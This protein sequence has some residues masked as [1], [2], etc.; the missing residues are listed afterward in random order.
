MHGWCGRI[1][2]VD[3]TRGTIAEEALP[4]E[5][6]RD[7]VG[8][9]GFGV[10][11]L[12]RAMDPTSD[13]LGEENVLVMAAGPLTGTAAPTGGRY[14]V[15]C[16]SPLT[17]AI[18]C[19]NSGGRFPTVLK[20]AGIDMLVF[21][22]RSPSPVYLWIDRG[23]A[24]LRPAEHLSGKTT[25]EADKALREET[26]PEAAV[27]SIGPA[28]E[29]GVLF[30][31]IM[32]DRHR[33]AGRSGVGAVMGSKNLKA[34]AVRGEASVPIHAPEAFRQVVKKYLRRFREALKGQPPPMRLYGTAATIVGTQT[35]GALPTRNF[36]Q[37]TFEGW[38]ALSGQTLAQTYLVRPSAC[39]A[40]P[41]ACGR[42]T[43]VRV[44][45]YEGEGEG[46]EYETVYAMGSNCGIDNLAAVTRAN[47]ICNAQGM[48]TI[49][50]GATLACAMEMYEKGL[51]PEK[52]IGRPLPFGDA[53]A[54]VEMTRLTAERRGFGALLSLGSYRL[55]GH[56]G[57]PEM[58]IVAKKQEFAGYEPRAEQGMGLAYAT[59][60][61]G[62]SHMRGDPAYIEIL[63]VPMRI[64]PL[65]WE[66]KG[67]LVA[68]WQDSFAVIDAAGLCVFFSVRNL[69]VPDREIR[70]EGIRELLNAAT[71]AD[72][73]LE[74][75]CRAGKRIFEAERLF[76]VG[77]GFSRKD[78]TLPDRIL[79]TPLPDGPAKG[80]VCRLDEMLDTYYRYRGWDENGVPLP[81]TLRALGLALPA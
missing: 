33:A 12:L 65:T 55:A 57:H 47:Y 9:R 79:K 53:E 63:G 40:C 22:G 60:P 4:P 56:Y 27:A 51:I 80:M 7:Y 48:D 59:S 30:A 35:V 17:G 54:L 73:S 14:M 10:R 36:Q 34:V 46:P 3:L 43:R 13:P 76:L 64:D 58:A 24:E 23:R 16:K 6:A 31:S 67:K 81:S 72:Y 21:T 49:S 1:L 52:D 5:V 38:K 69:V 42:V 28:G 68:D 75:L 8:G 62:A 74:D 37:G 44:P 70:P 61:I 39:H 71:G 18:T 19:A 26:H 2:N 78:D 50:M 15:T 41:I 29:R 45:G 77:A 11:T 66:D 20:K 25:H 32:N